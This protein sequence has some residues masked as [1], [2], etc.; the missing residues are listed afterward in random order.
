MGKLTDAVE[1]NLV[2]IAE[3]IC[4]MLDNGTAPW[5]KPWSS[6][7]LSIFPVNATTN[8]PYGGV[9][10]PIALWM[11]NSAKGYN[12][13]RWAGFGQW[14]DSGNPVRKEENKNYA[15]IFMPQIGTAKG[16]DGEKKSFLRGFKLGMVYNNQQTEN[17][18]PCI[19]VKEVDPTIGYEKAATALGK[20]GVRVQHGGGQAFYNP[21]S[22]YI[23]LPPAGA[24]ESVDH[25]WSTALH[26]LSHATG[27]KDRLNRDG[28]VK[29]S[30]FGTQAYAEEE[31]IAEI[32]SAFL[33]HTLG[34]KREGLIEHHAAYIASWKKR[35]KEKPEVLLES[36]QAA[37]RVVRWVENKAGV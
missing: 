22:D 2:T 4:I 15:V 27:S 33:C 5:V 1:A 20:S 7:G 35:I 19:E 13:D 37:S 6:A 8:R 10:N 31:L 14:R 36:M 25:Y 28:I 23:G 18:I 26:E 16:D 9:L 17:P 12:D 11:E 29:F 3:Q 24:F 30:G 34:I 32:G 21:A